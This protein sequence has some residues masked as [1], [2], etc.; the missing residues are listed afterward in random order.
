MALPDSCSQQTVFGRII[1]FL[2]GFMQPECNVSARQNGRPDARPSRAGLSPL[3]LQLYGGTMC[4][5]IVKS[6]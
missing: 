2:T 4:K 3:G 5:I 1:I 6:A